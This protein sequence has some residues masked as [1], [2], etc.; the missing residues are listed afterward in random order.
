MAEFIDLN[1]LRARAA[2]LITSVGSHPSDSVIEEYSNLVKQ[3][4]ANGGERSELD[5]ILI[6]FC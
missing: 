1:Q 2:E 6:K 5:P 3:F 4:L